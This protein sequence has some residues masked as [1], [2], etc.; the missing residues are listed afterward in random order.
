MRRVAQLGTMPETFRLRDLR[1]VRRGFLNLLDF[2]PD[3][4]PYRF[5]L[6]ERGGACAMLP[7]DWERGL[8][9]LLCAPRHL[10]A[11]ALLPEGRAAV[12]RAL[13][14][15]ASPEEIAAPRDV[16]VAWG[17]P[18]GMIEEGEPPRAAAARELAEETGLHVAAETFVHVATVFPSVGGSTEQLHLYL[19]PL[20][21]PVGELHP[22]GDGHETGEVWELTF[23]EAFALLDCGQIT[24][25]SSLILLQHLREDARLRHLTF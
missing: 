6:M 5:D 10:R 13:A 11:Y 21:G 20:R 23:R 12:R 19:A 15:G 3:D 14:E 8:A 18:A 17:V 16:V 22:R 2:Q 1:V 4:R 24:H 7:V 25:A 9:Y